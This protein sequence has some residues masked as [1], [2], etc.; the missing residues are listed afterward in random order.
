LEVR[1]TSVTEQFATVSLSGPNARRLLAEL[2]DDIELSTNAL[3]HMG[4]AKGTVAGIRARV[5][6]VSFTGEM[7]YEVNVPASYGLALWQAVMTAGEKYNITPFGTETMHVLRA[8]KG[9]I[10][11]GQE[12][13]GSVTPLDLGMDWIVSKKKDFV[14]KRSLTRPDMLKPDRKQLVGLLTEDPNEVLPEGA[15][16]VE[17]LRD[18]PPMTMVGHVS[19]SYYSPNLERS[20]ALALVKGGRAKMGHKLLSPLAGGKTVACT[21]TRPVFLDPDGERLRG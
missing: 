1:L 5:F 19:S 11:V 10:I 8:E 9:F 6:R 4:W 20:F 7:S 15:Q 21:I 3:P 13:D 18:K 16:L 2:T 14:G 12:T 17:T